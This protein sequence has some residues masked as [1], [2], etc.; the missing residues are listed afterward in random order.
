MA[1]YL[2]RLEGE[3]L[4]QPAAAEASPT[5]SEHILFVDDEEML[6]EASRLILESMGH[7]VTT[8][9]N[10]VGALNLFRAQAWNF[11]L[12]I[13]DV[14]MPKMNGIELARK[15]IEIRPD[16]P[17]ILTTGFTDLIKPEEAA[18]IGIREVLI[19]PYSKRDLGK[20]IRRVLDKPQVPDN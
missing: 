13:S 16:I 4:S 3:A 7:K 20:T 5:G 12:V 1:V 11:D 19:K 6:A 18:G 2:P 15:L 9:V 17:I 14:T 8:R 10:S